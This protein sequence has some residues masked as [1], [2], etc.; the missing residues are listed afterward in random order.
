MPVSQWW[1]VLSNVMC[2]KYGLRR[3]TRHPIAVLICR[4]SAAACDGR[5]V[6]VTEWQPSFRDTGHIA[7]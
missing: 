3:I 5:S 2:D 4:G 6:R 1:P 7:A